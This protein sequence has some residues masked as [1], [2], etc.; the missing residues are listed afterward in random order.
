MTDILVFHNILWSH[1]KGAVFSQLYRQAQASG[2]TISFVQIAETEKGSNSLSSVDLAIHQ[3]PYQLLFSG[4]YENISFL[5]KSLALSGAL[6]RHRPKVVVLPGFSDPAFW[7]L[8]LLG[9]LAGCRPIL[10]FDSQRIDRP[11]FPFRELVK[12]IFVRLCDLGFT[13]GT[14]SKEYLQALGMAEQNIVVR[15]QAAV[16]DEVFSIYSTAR[17]SRQHIQKELGLKSRNFVY[18][19]RLSHEKNVAMLL[20][21]FARVP[22]PNRASWGLVIVG[23]GPLRNNLRELTASLELPDVVFVGGKAWREVPAI[24]AAADV[25]VLPSLSEAWGLVVN[26]AMACGMPVIVSDHCGAAFD[27]VQHG[28]NGFVFA[29]RSQDDLT[30]QLSAILL[31][32]DRELIAMGDASR[33]IIANFTPASAARQMMTGFS[34]LLNADHSATQR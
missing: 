21:S 6:L 20:R 32:E 18:V 29:A 15:V 7:V 33:R 23:D 19:G 9:R 2:F 10:T 24:L 25:L 16:N 26:E 28:V 3:Y 1:Y 34:R 31:K 17:Q 4:C 12:T 13:Y 30:N 22:L 27:L 8:L 5:R 11:R 14:K